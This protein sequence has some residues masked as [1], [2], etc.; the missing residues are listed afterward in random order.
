MIETI[1]V[2][3]SSLFRKYRWLFCLSFFCFKGIKMV[4]NNFQ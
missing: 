1:M 3:F 2:I 4:L